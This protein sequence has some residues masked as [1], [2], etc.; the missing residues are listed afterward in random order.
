VRDLPAAAVRVQGAVRA[1]LDARRDLREIGF[2]QGRRFLVVIVAGW[3]ALALATTADVYMYF[4][5]VAQPVSLAWVFASQ[6]PGWALWAVA[7]VP[8]LRLSRR[9]PLWP[10]R[11]RTLAVHGAA[12]LAVA[13]GF[14]AVSLIVDRLFPLPSPSA[15]LPVLVK[16]R[17]R[18]ISWSPSMLTAYA[19]VI[20][21]G[22]ALAYA[23]Q[24][25]RAQR[26]KAAL[27]TQLVEA[28]LGALRMQLQP[29]FLFNTLNSIAMLVRS[30]D[31]A[32]AVEMIALLGDVLRTLLRSSSDL[33]SSLAAELAL[34][35]RYLA[36]EQIRFADRLRVTWH[37][38]PAAE[39]V[40]V[41][42][43][44]LQ[45]IV[46]NALRHGLWPRPDGGELTITARRRDDALVL[47]VI[48]DGVGLPAD[49]AI[50]DARGVGLGN[51]RTRL[52]RMYGDA[53]GFE[54]VRGAPRGVTVRLR[55]PWRAGADG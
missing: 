30:A 25:E 2:L 9:F 28:Q 34:L 21:A 39:A 16:L 41:P 49:F 3:L 14:V 27:A 15:V 17:Q 45:P 43:L 12:L 51:V 10:V 13:L 32:R 46:E 42:P 36:I 20:G 50:D 47:E 26:E 6:A 33:E 1:R 38:A 18:L 29:H 23:A 40:H 53:A 37:I 4:V 55:V 11:G 7:T 31:N 8:L 24:V 48:D 5:R 52:A 44:I 54:I 22:H 19:G 35:R